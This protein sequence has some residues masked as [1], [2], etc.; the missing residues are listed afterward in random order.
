M[1]EILMIV[2]SEKRGN[3]CCTTLEKEEDTHTR[4]S[5]EL[6]ERS[7]RSTVVHGQ[8]P[9]KT[10]VRRRKYNNFHRRIR[11]GLEAHHICK[12]TRCPHDTTLNS[13]RSL[14]TWS[15]QRYR[16]CSRAQ[17]KTR[18]CKV[19]QFIWEVS[20]SVLLLTWIQFQREVCQS[21][22]WTKCWKIELSNV[23][24]SNSKE[25]RE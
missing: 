25:L 12:K 21:Q 24:K 17:D 1:D 18:S 22:F 9:I 23:F 3:R 6:W 5:V 2:I 7:V 4:A 8:R 20:L 10:S 13:T 14:N 16:K 11:N 15:F 19:T